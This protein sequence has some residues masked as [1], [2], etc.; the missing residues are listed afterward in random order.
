MAYRV[1]AGKLVDSLIGVISY[2]ICWFSLVA[3]N[4][5]SL[6]LIFVILIIL[7]HGIFLCGLILYD[8]LHFLD[9]G[10]CPFSRLGKFFSYYL[11]KYFLRPLLSLP[12]G[13]PIMQMLA[14]LMLSQKS[15]KLSS[16]FFILFSVPCHLLPPL[17]LPP[18]WSVLLPHLL[19]YR[20][21]LV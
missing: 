17:C 8:T 21:L 4:I 16:F 11:F 1:S 10:N 2:V 14:C 3:F 6:S 7:C 5:F 12:S 19:Y 20:F 9:L 18:H 15:L 13:T